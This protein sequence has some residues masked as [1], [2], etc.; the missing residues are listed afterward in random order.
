MG[1][2]LF[3]LGFTLVFVAMGTFMPYLGVLFAQWED[4]IIRVLGIVGLIA[5]FIFMGGFGLMQR[6]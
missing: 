1:I 2:S 6:N 3:V 5:G 4:I